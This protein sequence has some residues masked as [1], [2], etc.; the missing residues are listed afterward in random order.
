MRLIGYLFAIGFVGCP[1]FFCFAPGRAVRFRCR[2]AGSMLRLRAVHG[3]S[4]EFIS[5][6]RGFI[7][8]P[9]LRGLLPELSES[10]AGCL[11]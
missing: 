5:V 1:C 7:A 4:I 9:T 10:F 2:V 3:D 11:G 8:R 6:Q